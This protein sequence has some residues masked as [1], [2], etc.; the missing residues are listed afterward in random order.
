[1]SDSSEACRFRLSMPDF[2]F[3]ALKV[4]RLG[5]VGIEPFVEPF[6]SFDWLDCFF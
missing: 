3:S 5:R 1:M 6:V 2:Q 4:A